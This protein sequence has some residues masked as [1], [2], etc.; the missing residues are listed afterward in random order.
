MSPEYGATCGIFPVDA[1]TLRYLE[2]TGR[3]AGAGR[4][5]RGLL[6]GA[7]PVPRRRARRRP[8]YSDTLELDLGDG[9]AEPRRPAAPAGPRRAHRREASDFAPSCAESTDGDEPRAAATRRPRRP[10]RPATRRPTTAAASRRAAAAHGAPRESAGDRRTLERRTSGLDHGYVVIAAITSCTNTSNPSVMLGAGLLA[11]KAVERGPR[12]QAVGEDQPRARLEGRDRLPRARRADRADLDAARLQPRRLRLHDLHRQLRPAAGGDLAGDRRSDD[13]VVVLG[14]VRQPQLR[15]P[16]QP[17]RAR[18]TTSPRRR[19]CVAY[20]LAGPDGHRPRRPSRSARRDGEPVYLRDIW[21][22]Q[23]EVDDGDRV[24][25]RV[26]HVPQELR[27]GVRGRRDLERA[28]GARG[29]PLRLGRGSRPTSSS[30]PTSTACRAEPPAASS[31]SSGA[32]VLALL[33]DSVTTDH[34]SPAGAIKKDSP[35]RAAT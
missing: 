21:P 27:R 17:R 18:R 23:R 7:G 8:T 29:R 13:L 1:E 31:R 15:G 6:Q 2:F 24:G 16:H 25:D 26:G 22:T 3:A 28:R 20:A 33:G 4:A 30:R 35:G 19:W 9:R 10:S 34:I 32:R 12:A 5:G 11:K 14:A